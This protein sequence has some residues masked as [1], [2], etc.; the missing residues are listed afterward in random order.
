M[1]HHDVLA[2]WTRTAGHVRSAGDA[3]EL[4]EDAS[5][6][7]SAVASNIAGVSSRAMLAALVAGERDPVVM[8][9]LARSKLRRKIPDL[10]EP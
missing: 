4:L 10:T 1:A 6:K 8:A 7:I 3:G 2:G 9:D 5:I